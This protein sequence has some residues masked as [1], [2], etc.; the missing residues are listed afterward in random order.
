MQG[1]GSPLGA[2]RHTVLQR[3]SHSIQLRATTMAA[4]MQYPLRLPSASLLVRPLQQHFVTFDCL[5]VD[6]SP[7]FLT[8]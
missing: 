6:W 5:V 4:H 2:S 8:L 7:C 1:M 3:H